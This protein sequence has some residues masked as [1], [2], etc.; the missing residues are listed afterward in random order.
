MEDYFKI[1]N[2]GM[3]SLANIIFHG[4]SQV[5]FNPFSS[6][7]NRA[8]RFPKIL[9]TTQSNESIR[10]EIAIKYLRPLSLSKSVGA[11]FSRKSGNPDDGLSMGVPGGAV[12]Q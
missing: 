5:E 9:K 4:I 6:H 3:V 1:E 12:A 2:I 10:H 7:S 11:L 8:R